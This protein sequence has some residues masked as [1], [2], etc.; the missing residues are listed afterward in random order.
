MVQDKFIEVVGTKYQIKGEG[1]MAIAVR[2]HGN[3]I[4]V[5]V[6]PE[7]WLVPAGSTVIPS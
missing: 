7:A 2:R 5:L 3:D 4:V 6:D 1:M